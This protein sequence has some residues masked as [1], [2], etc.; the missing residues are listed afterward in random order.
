MELDVAVQVESTKPNPADLIDL[1]QP[2]EELAKLNQRQATLV[3]LRYFG[4]SENTEIAAVLGISEPT[5]NRDW[6]GAHAWLYDR[7]KTSSG[8]PLLAP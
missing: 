6:R 4:G 2:L 3:E 7:L 5:V 1:D 8:D